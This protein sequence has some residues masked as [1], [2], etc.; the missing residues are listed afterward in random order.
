MTGR[1]LRLHLRARGASAFVAGVSVITLLAWAGGTWLAGR[2]FLD[3]PA[4]RLPVALLAP[5][6]AAVLLGSTLAGADEELERGTPLRWPA[7]RAGQVLLAVLAVAGALVLTGL[8]V[9]ETFGAHALA[10]NTLGWIGLVAGA[11]A[12]LGARLAWLPAFG[13]GC[14]V[15]FARP[16]DTGVF[17]ALWSWPVQ[18]SAVAASWW[19]ASGVF[20]LGLVGY[21]YRGSAVG[22]RFRPSQ[23]RSEVD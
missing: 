9:P 19:A 11:T 21:A 23:S 2:S 7:W 10:R 18:P 20:V 16:R 3:G 22:R 17:V 6:L 14:A 12:L 15:Y 8:R 13:Y 1:L 5:L 4:A